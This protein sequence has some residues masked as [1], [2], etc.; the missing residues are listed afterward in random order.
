[1]LDY[2]DE[3]IM[4]V[5]WYNTIKTGVLEASHRNM[6]ILSHPAAPMKLE[7]S[8]ALFMQLLYHSATLNL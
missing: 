2:F 4:W 8:V 5:L 6:A 3:S 7:L 1:M